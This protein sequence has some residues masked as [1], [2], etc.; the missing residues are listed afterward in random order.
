MDRRLAAQ[1]DRT[2]PASLT[3]SPVARASI[4]LNA[5]LGESY[6]RWTLGNDDALLER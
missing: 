5:D 3:A 2:S 1:Q 4:D 6:G